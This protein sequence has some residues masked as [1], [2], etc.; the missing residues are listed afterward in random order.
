MCKYKYT[1]YMLRLH[2]IRH[3]MATET[4]IC[5]FPTGAGGVEVIFETFIKSQSSPCY[6][7]KI[8]CIC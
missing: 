4:Q 1:C 8:I 3:N 2:V 5:I 7:I 6:V